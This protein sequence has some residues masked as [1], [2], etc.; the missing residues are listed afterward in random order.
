MKLPV[1]IIGGG[2]VGF[3]AAAQL[4]ERGESFDLFEAGSE[5]GASVLEW[6]HVRMFSPWEYTMDESAVRLLSAHDWEAPHGGDIPTGRELIEKYLQPLA[7]LPEIAPFVHLNSQVIA[8]GKKDLD[9]MKSRGRE[10]APFV[11]RYKQDGQIRQ[12]EARA[13]IDASGTWKQPN[14]LGAGGAFA[15]GEAEAADRITYGIPDVYGKQRHRYAG[16]RVLVVGSGHSAINTLLDLNRLKEEVPTTE[17]MWLLRK[18]DVRE[19]YGGGEAD[20]LQARGALGTAIQSLVESGR[21]SV[22]T[23]AYIQEV[24]TKNNG[25]VVTGVWNGAPMRL[26]GIDEIITNTGSRPDAQFLREVRFQL[27]AAIECVPALAELIDP[28]I[29]SCGTVRPHGERELRQPEKDFYIVGMKS[30]GRAP[31]F[32]LATGYEQVRSVVAALAGD[33]EAAE[34]V[35][36]RLPETGVCNVGGPLYAKKAETS[37]CGPITKKTA[38]CCE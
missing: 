18:K 33:W 6:G 5:V 25:L 21:V 16:K 12:I 3:A 19:A 34:R 32:L 17:I 1:A 26:D 2:P 10:Q 28:N 35:E 37:C 30:Y 29:H 14:P 7:D 22:Y 15:V 27:D 11:V 36:L 13:V 24:S 23:P 38:S 20:Q 4:L 9:K 31:T 8:V